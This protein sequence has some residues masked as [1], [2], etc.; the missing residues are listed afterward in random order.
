MRCVANWKA[1]GSGALAAPNGG[2]CRIS[3]NDDG[4]EDAGPVFEVVTAPEG[5]GGFTS[6]TVF[7]DD[8]EWIE[9]W[10]TAASAGDAVSTNN[11][12]TTAP[13]VFTTAACEGFLAAAVAKGYGYF[14]GP[15]DG[16][17]SD[18]LG[19]DNPKVLYLQKNYLK[20]GKTAYNAGIKLP[21]LSALTAKANI[22]LTFDWCWQITGSNNADIMTL[23]ILVDGD[24]SYAGGEI[25][26]AQS[27][28]SG[29]S[30][31]EWQHAKVTVSGVS[32]TTRLSICP[33]NADPKVSNPDRNQNRWYLDNIKIVTVE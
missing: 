3:D 15:K 11:P 16:N 32:P 12:S 28:E 8:F 13:N 10:A 6:V 19:D 24:G 30:K 18:S 2:T 7:E 14:W 5:G 23:T 20:F 17:W 21:A 4:K 33:T 26:S 22:E 1:D 29:A 25:T 31:I 27:T 9:P